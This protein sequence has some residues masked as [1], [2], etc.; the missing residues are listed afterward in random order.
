MTKKTEEQEKT[1][2]NQEQGRVMS[3]VVQLPIPQEFEGK[4]YSK[5]DLSG[6]RDLNTADMGRAEQLFQTF[7]YTDPAKE[8]NTQFCMIVAHFATG[9][10]FEFFNQLKLPNC[11]RIKTVVSGF[12]YASA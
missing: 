7:G 5:I 12:L 10:P 6:L 2:K 4:T 3:F 8:F 9:L 11:I 1:T